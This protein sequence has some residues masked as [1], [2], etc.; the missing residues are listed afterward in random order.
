M[1]RFL[2]FNAQTHHHKPKKTVQSS[3]GAMHKT[4]EDASQVQATKGLPRAVGIS[5]L[6][7]KQ[8]DAQIQHGATATPITSTSSEGVKCECNLDID[9]RIPLIGHIKKSFSL[10]DGLYQEGSTA[11]KNAAEDESDH[12]FSSLN[13]LVAPDGSNHLLSQLQND[14][15]LESVQVSSD[16][17]HNESIFSI[18]DPHHSD[19][20]GCENSDS[21]QSAEFANDSGDHSPYAECLIVKSCSMPNIIPSGS[22]SA[23]CSPFKYSAPSSRSFEDL[24]VLEMYQKETSVHGFDMEVVREQE[25][26]GI[27]PRAETHNFSNYDA[28]DSYSYSALAKDW[29]V[30]VTDEIN[31]EKNHQGELAAEGWDE[32]TSNAFKFRRIEEWVNDF[33]H[34]SP[35]EETGVLF[36][37]N[38]NVSTEPSVMNGLTVTKADAKMNPSMEAAKKYISSL[39]A[40]ATTAQLANQGLLIIPFLSGFASLRVLNLSGNAIVSITAGA[41]PRGLHTLN[42]SKNNISTIEGLRGLA[43]LRVLDLSYNRIFRIA[44]GLASCSSLKELY[45]ARNKISEIE[46]LHRLLKLTVLDLR[47][48]KISTAKCLGQLTANYNSLQAIS[49]EGNPAQKNVGDEQLKKYLQGLLPHLSY[50]NRQPIKSSSLKDSADRSVR[51]GI[52]GSSH[53]FDRGLR[54]EHKV[55]RKSG[56]VVGERIQSFASTHGQKNQTVVSAKQSRGRHAH[57]PPPV[58]TRAAA[59]QRHH[60]YF[61]FSSKLPNLKSELSIQRTQSE[62]T[63]GAF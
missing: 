2:C 29:I 17:V 51:L 36:H 49:L 22:T 1:V 15:D 40:L 56:H 8:G 53:Q 45:L 6:T 21:P 62:G 50:F 26:D 38:D 34:C 12:G 44:H 11:G 52:G 13:M 46:G 42:L 31:S 57:L 4:L 10:G 61:D 58:R 41:L 54:A 24:H 63:H 30:P 9:V 47:F 60:H 59:N 39:S 19:K 3:V 43:R 20:E 37:S 14:L 18:G 27:M 35:V 5:F 23:G 33:Q 7:K 32:S 55:S 28:Y 48:N 25:K 16:I